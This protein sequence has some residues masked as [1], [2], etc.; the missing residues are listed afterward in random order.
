M[1]TEFGRYWVNIV[2]VVLN[3][4]EESCDV[5]CLMMPIEDMEVRAR[6]F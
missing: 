3:L 1:M 2:L 5:V 6:L 4:L